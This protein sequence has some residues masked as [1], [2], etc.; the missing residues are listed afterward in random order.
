MYKLVNKCIST[1]GIPCTGDRSKIFVYTRKFVC[2]N[3][4]DLYIIDF[5]FKFSVLEVDVVILS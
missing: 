4:R 2:T 5:K 1:D 3:L